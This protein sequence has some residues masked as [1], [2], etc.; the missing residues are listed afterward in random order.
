[1]LLPFF[2]PFHFYSCTGLFSSYFLGDAVNHLIIARTDVP[3]WKSYTTWVTYFGCKYHFR[4][5]Q[6]PRISLKGWV[7]GDG[8]WPPQAKPLLHMGCLPS[9]LCTPLVVFPIFLKSR[10]NWFSVTVASWLDR[11][12]CKKWDWLGITLWWPCVPS[13]FFEQCIWLCIICIYLQS[14]FTVTLHL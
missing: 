1:M 11:Q 2:S 10:S 4:N 12:L 3:S 13:I 8:F 14:Q 7:E 5:M 9:C 6:K